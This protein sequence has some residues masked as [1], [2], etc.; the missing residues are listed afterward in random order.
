[1][2]AVMAA[3]RR[4]AVADA[5]LALREFLAAQRRLRGREAQRHGTLS[6]SQY[7]VLRVLVDGDEHP[8][9]ELAA[10]ADVSPA[11]A[12]KMIDGLER[13]GLVARVRGSEDRRR[14]DVTITE[15]G[16]DVLGR[17][18]GEIQEAWER[19]LGDAEPEEIAAIA[20]ALRRVV[21]IY[22]GL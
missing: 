11:S 22:E 8:I 7:A 3:G 10:A 2:G 16:R 6:F 13:A 4:E 12:T 20:A 1:M 15:A 14:V 9:G 5:R 21:A 18:D 19:V 17:K